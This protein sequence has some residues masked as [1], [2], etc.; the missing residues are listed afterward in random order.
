MVDNQKYLIVALAKDF[1]Y[2][3]NNEVQGVPNFFSLV[4]WSI[5]L[6]KGYFLYPVVYRGCMDEVRS[7]YKRNQVD[8]SVTSIWAKKISA[9]N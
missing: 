8:W 6:K 5:R 4:L 2:S 7:I 9:Q 1:K 3:D